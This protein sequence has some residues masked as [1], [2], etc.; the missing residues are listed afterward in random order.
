MLPLAF[1]KT[2]RRRQMFGW[3]NVSMM[4][5]SRLDVCLAA[6]EAVVGAGPWR[7]VCR[8][9]S[10]RHSV[11]Q[12]I[13]ASWMT[14]TAT[15]SPELMWSALYT[16]ANEPLPSSVDMSY[17]WYSARFTTPDTRS[18]KMKPKSA[19]RRHLNEL[20]TRRTVVKEPVLLPGRRGYAKGDL[21]PV[22]QKALL[23]L[24]DLL[25]V[26]LRWCKQRARASKTGR[27]AHRCRCSTCPR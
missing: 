3:R 16:V 4:L 10:C 17:E 6:S 12:R 18:R 1:Q 5:I 15:H 11:R 26:N 9:L 14:L 7:F 20:Q 24:A 25:S 23:A 8:R 2:S 21:V 27:N 13:R 22:F 19:V